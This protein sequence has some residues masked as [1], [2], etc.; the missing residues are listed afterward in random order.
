MI[1]TNCKVIFL[2]ISRPK[3][4]LKR[5]MRKEKEK[6]VISF[7]SDGELERIVGLLDKLSA[8]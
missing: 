1:I 8:K 3:V 7:K 5:N 4:D 6:I 2:V